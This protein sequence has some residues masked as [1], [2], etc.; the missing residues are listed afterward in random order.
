MQVMIKWPKRLGVKLVFFKPQG[1]CRQKTK[2][3]HTVS[4]QKAI[5]R[6]DPATPRY[7]Q[8]RCFAYK[9]PYVFKHKGLCQALA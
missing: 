1:F 8:K 4:T 3:E 2:L 6:T 5:N 7:G 9:K